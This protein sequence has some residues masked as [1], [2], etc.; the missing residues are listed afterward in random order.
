MMGSTLD[1]LDMILSL[2]LALKFRIW[3]TR[4]LSSKFPGDGEPHNQ[5][6]A[7]CG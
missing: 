6:L 2:L 5:T 3:S 4:S 1:Y 7:V